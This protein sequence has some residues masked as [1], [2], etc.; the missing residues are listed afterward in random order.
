MDY[1]SQKLSKEN[2][3]LKCQLEDLQKDVEEIQCLKV[4]IK[5]L[6]E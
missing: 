5:E 2:I 3:R 6:T 4:Q 1:K